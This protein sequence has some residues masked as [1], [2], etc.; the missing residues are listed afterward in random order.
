M[1]INR[2]INF[3]R[4]LYYTE[5]IFA[6]CVRTRMFKKFYFFLSI[7]RRLLT[8]IFITKRTVVIICFQHF[9]KFALIW[10]MKVA[11]RGKRKFF[12]DSFSRQVHKKKCWNTHSQVANIIT[13]FH[14]SK[15]FIFC[16]DFIWNSNK[17]NVI[18]ET[19]W[20]KDTKKINECNYGF[21][22]QFYFF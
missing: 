21:F 7:N 10:W 19:E 22:F 5:E 1:H 11:T 9:K 4:L 8:T 17:I 13:L 18:N 15:A 20:N 2:F 16:V 6:L 14:L 12:I 3:I